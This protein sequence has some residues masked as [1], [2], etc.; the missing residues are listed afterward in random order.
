MVLMMLN[1]V[2]MTWGCHHQKRRRG[3]Q[4]RPQDYQQSTIQWLSLQSCASCFGKE[5]TTYLIQLFAF[6]L[7]FSKGD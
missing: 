3:R 6:Y 4:Q 2:L 5:G 1:S 7:P